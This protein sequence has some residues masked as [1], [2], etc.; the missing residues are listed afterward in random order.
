MADR[1]GK[2]G[3][4]TGQKTGGKRQ[5]RTSNCRHQRR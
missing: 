4:R 1:G 2:D 5:N 3:K